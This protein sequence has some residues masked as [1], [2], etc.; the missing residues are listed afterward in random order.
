MIVKKNERNESLR[1]FLRKSL[2]S[3]NPKNESFHT[4]NT[5]NPEQPPSRLSVQPFGPPRLK[6]KRE[7][8]KVVGPPPG[9]AQQYLTL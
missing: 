4:L 9:L 8:S 3:K 7:H 2:D 6:K 5:S 1:S